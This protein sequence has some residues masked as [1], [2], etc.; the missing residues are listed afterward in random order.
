MPAD[1]NRRISLSVYMD[2]GRQSST[3]S[4][5]PFI[6]MHKVDKEPFWPQSK[7]LGVYPQRESREGSKLS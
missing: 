2:T 1:L 6:L 5:Y 4:L 7:R 3:G